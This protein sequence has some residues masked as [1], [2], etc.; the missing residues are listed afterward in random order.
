MG[1]LADSITQVEADDAAILAV[2]TPIGTSIAEIQTELASSGDVPA[3]LVS[4]AQLHTDLS[5]AAT[6]LGADAATLGTLANPST[7]PAAKQS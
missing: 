7:I 2:I 3:A 6:S 5:G 1:L 4:L